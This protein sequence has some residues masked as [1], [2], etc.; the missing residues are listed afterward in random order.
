MLPIHAQA[1]KAANFERHNRQLPCKFAQQTPS[2]VHASAP[3]GVSV[4]GS[5]QLV[6]LHRPLSNMLLLLPGSVAV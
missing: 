1:G 6:E 4:L 3:A 2:Q 5:F